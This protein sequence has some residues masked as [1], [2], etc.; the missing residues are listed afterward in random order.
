LSLG[1]LRRGE[2]IAGLSGASLVVFLF[3]LHWY[4]VNGTFGRTLALGLHARTSWTGWQ[5]L[6]YVRWLL[7]VTALVALALAYFQAAER[8]PAIPVALAVIV[9]VLGGLSTLALV[10][11]VIDTPGNHL[12]RQ[13]GVYLG[14]AAAMGIAYGGFRSLREESGADPAALD[15]ETVSLPG[16]T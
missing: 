3:A 10:A 16:R 8:A 6:T 14:L 15:I 4:D 5:A 7:L 11:R 12:D 13:A 9:T 1:R 2:L